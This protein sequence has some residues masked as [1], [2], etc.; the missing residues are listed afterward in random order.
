M[1]T[2]LPNGFLQRGRRPCDPVGAR[3][4][5]EGVNLASPPPRLPSLPLLRPLVPPFLLVRPDRR[6]VARVS[7][8]DYHEIEFYRHPGT[9]FPLLS[10]EPFPPPPGSLPTSL[11]VKLRAS[12]SEHWTFKLSVSPSSRA[13]A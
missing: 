9:L 7:T 5:V 10:Q 6:D 3:Q 13:R 4:P 8:V 1:G 2:L 12:S 11:F